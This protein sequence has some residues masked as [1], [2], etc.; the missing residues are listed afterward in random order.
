[1]FW[2]CYKRGKETRLEKER[3]LT[4]QELLKLDVEYR[5]NHPG[6]HLTT[7][8]PG[9]SIEDVKAGI[10]E[11]EE[12]KAAEA[13]ATSAVNSKQQDQVAH[14]SALDKTTKPEMASTTMET[15][16]GNQSNVV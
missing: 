5:A 4:E 2:Y 6:V 9:A 10:A 13:L 15:N 1:M 12:A 8:E 16:P 7:A 11:I 3:E 14:A